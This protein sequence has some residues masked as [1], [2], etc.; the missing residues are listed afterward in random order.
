LKINYE[1]LILDVLKTCGGPTVP[2]TSKE[3][4][5]NTLKKYPG[6]SDLSKVKIINTM[7]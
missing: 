5:E 6:A 1:D 4:Y 7:K 3:I 2:Q